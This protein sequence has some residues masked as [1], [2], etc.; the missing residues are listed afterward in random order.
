MENKSSALAI[1]FIRSLLG[2]IFFW[3]GYGKVFNW[4]LSNVYN[5][6]F[7]SFEELGLS[8]WF[9]KLVLYFTSFAELIVGM[10]LILGLFR[11]WAYFLIISLLLI[12]A[13]GHGLQEGI[14]NLSHVFYRAALLL[15]LLLL[16]FHHDKYC[17][18]VYLK[19]KSE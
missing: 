1:F 11:K 10:L 5:S 6:T 13:F 19:K 8:E 9:L 14:W 15:P 2:I 12:V 18:D 16:P 7:K 3:Q 4:G 17:L